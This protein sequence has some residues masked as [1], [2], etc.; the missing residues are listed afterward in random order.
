MMLTTTGAKSGHARTIPLVAIP[1]GERVV[2]IASNWGGEHSPAWYHNLC[3]HPEATLGY[4]GRTQEYRARELKGKEYDAYWQRVVSLYRGYEA[5][6]ARTNG[7]PIPLML[8]DP[9]KVGG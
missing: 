9:L 2:L 3:A 1:D 8:L 5:Y 6:K 7:R 4:G